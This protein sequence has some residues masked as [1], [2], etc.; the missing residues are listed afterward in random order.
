MAVA[1]RLAP[2]QVVAKV[3]PSMVLSLAMMTLS[4]TPIEWPLPLPGPAL[5]H[6]NTTAWQVEGG[7]WVQG[8]GQWVWEAVA[9][10][11]HQTRTT[12]SLVSV[13]LVWALIDLARTL[14]A[15]LRATPPTKTLASPLPQARAVT[16]TQHRAA[17]GSATGGG[18]V[19]QWLGAQPLGPC[20][21][22]HHAA[23][24]RRK[25]GG[26]G[27]VGQDGHCT[28]GG[29]V[30]TAVHKR[31]SSI[32]AGAIAPGIAG[33]IAPSPA[34]P[35]GYAHSLQASH[36]SAHS[37]TW[38]WVTKETMASFLAHD[39]Q[40][41]HAILFT[42][43]PKLPALVEQ[44][45]QVFAGR[46][47]FAC[48][49]TEEEEVLEAYGVKTNLVPRFVLPL[50]NLP[51]SQAEHY[52]GR[53]DLV[54]LSTFIAHHLAFYPSRAN[55]SVVAGPPG[56]TTPAAAAAAALRQEECAQVAEVELDQAAGGCISTAL[57]ALR[58]SSLPVV[59]MVL[60]HE[61]HLPQAWQ[62]MARIFAN[63]LTLAVVPH[64][65]VSII[66]SCVTRRIHIFDVTHSCVT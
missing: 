39:A 7:H 26:S 41:V 48:V 63:V 33:A 34:S 5:L 53:V 15:K 35:L 31:S 38:G 46:V 4:P 40:C 27:E 20:P 57:T 25:D 49:L 56:F 65:K 43:R 55:V 42:A 37:H 12:R 44:A 47:V 54:Q 10:A 62:V 64:H 3:L 36:L 17:G 59:L 23:Q 21:A 19:Q 61:Q 45:A 22:N 58:S 13:L 28:S 29:W 50:P 14:A 18:R 6:T 32:E 2:I 30:K 9:G 8:L 11:C 24:T 1:V 16:G 60:G 51:P 66:M 52:K